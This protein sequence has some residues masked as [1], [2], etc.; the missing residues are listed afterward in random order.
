MEFEEVF[1]Y[2]DKGIFVK[3]EKSHFKLG[4]GTPQFI[5]WLDKTHY[6]GIHEVLT[7]GIEYGKI[8]I[9]KIAHNKIDEVL[10]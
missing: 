9:D 1:K 10:S 8:V 7:S 5:I 3:R 6:A 4:V 2:K